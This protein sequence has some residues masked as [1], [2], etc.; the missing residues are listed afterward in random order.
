MNIDGD[1]LIKELE[2]MIEDIRID[3][4]LL[5]DDNTRDLWVKIIET[6]RMKTLKSVINAI[7]K[8]IV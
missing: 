6:N 3:L 1:K 7:K 8:S 5:D 2:H 4:L